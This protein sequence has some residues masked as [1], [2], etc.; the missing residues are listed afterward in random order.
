MLSS[1]AGLAL[2]NLVVLLYPAPI[3]ILIA[4]P[5]QK[6]GLSFGSGFAHLHSQFAASTQRSG[7]KG[8][9]EVRNLS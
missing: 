3:T 7:D 9:R 8:N 1:L 4:G 5:N 6:H 2:S